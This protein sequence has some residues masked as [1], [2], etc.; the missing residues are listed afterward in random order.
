MF[1]FS[2]D[3]PPLAIG[4]LLT[5]SGFNPFQLISRTFLG[6]IFGG[7]MEGRKG[8]NHLCVFQELDLSLSLQLRDVLIFLK[9][10]PWLKGLV[11]NVIFKVTFFSSSQG[12]SVTCTGPMS[13]EER[14]VHFDYPHSST[15][16]VLT[17]PV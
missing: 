17:G 7:G 9:P 10:C 5:Q 12:H 16:H 13:G 2:S 8:K 4:H 11:S 6:N 14:D 3:C 15:S 1:L